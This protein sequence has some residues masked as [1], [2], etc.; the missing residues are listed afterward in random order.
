MLDMVLIS[1]EG[2][3]YEI[4]YD[5]TF[6]ESAADHFKVY[7]KDRGLLKFAPEQFEFFHQHG[8]YPNWRFKPAFGDRFDNLRFEIIR[9]LLDKHKDRYLY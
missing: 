7:I 4:L 2:K 3:K 6:P 8:E 1:F 9:A 5:Y